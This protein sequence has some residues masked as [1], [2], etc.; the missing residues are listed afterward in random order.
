[1]AQSRHE[2]AAQPLAEYLDQLQSEGRYTFT[3]DGVER[4]LGLGPQALAAALRRLRVRGKVVTPRRG[5]HVVV[6]AEHRAAGAP[7]PSWFVDDLMRHLGQPYYVGLLTAAALH[8]AGHQQPMTFQ[9]V[10]DRP[11]R[12]LRVGRVR[13]AFHVARGIER[14]PVTELQTPTGRM[15]VSKQEA[16]AFDLVRFPSAGDPSQVA[17]VLSELAEVLSPDVLVAVAAGYSTPDIQRLGYLLEAVGEEE[18]ATALAGCLAGRR[19]RPVQLAP[20]SRGANAAP[21]PRWQV[22]PNIELE[23]ET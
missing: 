10:T 13:I 20:R 5:F 16:T 17:L 15:R 1:M 11:T 23:V 9:V 8:G 22:V 2:A 4:E 3:R 19:V 7:P 18:L 6:P 21:A 14:A 12:G